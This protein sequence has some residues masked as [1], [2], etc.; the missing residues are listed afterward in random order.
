MDGAQVDPM[1]FETT[2]GRR[3]AG[4]ALAAFRQERDRIDTLRA[5]QNG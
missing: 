5:A 2:S 3:L 4:V 1:N